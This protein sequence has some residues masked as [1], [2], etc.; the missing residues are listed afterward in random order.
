MKFLI[1]NQLPPIL[2]RHLQSHGLTATHVADVGLDQASDVDIRRYADE[3]GFTIVSKDEDFLHP[4]VSDPS[5]P[6]FVWVRI[7]NCRKSALLAAF[8]HVR[9]HLIQALN[10]GQK[11]IEIQ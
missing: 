5:G 4:S 9:S 7:G 3:G 6:S 8:D 1:D 11:V 2:V 10:E